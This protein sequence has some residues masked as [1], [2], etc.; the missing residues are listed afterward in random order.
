[1]EQDQCRGKNHVGHRPKGTRPCE[2]CHPGQIWETNA[3]TRARWVESLESVRKTLKEVEREEEQEN[4]GE[5][6]EWQKVTLP[7]RKG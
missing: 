7:T 5:R 1:M 2:E 4:Q 6:G 3:K